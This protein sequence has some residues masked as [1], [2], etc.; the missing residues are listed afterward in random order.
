MTPRSRRLWRPVFAIAVGSVIVALVVCVLRPRGELSPQTE[1]AAWKELATRGNDLRLWLRFID[2]HADEE[3]SPISDEAIRRQLARI[4]SGSVATLAAFWYEHVSKEAKPDAQTLA[5]A[6]ATKPP[7]YAN[8]LLARAALDD[9]D[10]QWQEAARRFE[11]EGLAF[12]DDWRDLE[13]A[14]ATYVDHDA[15]DEVRKRSHDPRY[16]KVLHASFRLELAIH[17]RDWAGILVWLWPAG[18]VATKPWPIALAVLSAVLWLIITTRLGRVIDHVRGRALLYTLAFILGIL[19]IYPTLLISVVEEDIFH[20]RI[21]NQTVPDGLYFIFGVGLR[22]EAAKLLLFLP[23][24]PALLRRGS[25]IEVMTCGA[26]VG[27]GF[28][29]E[30]NIGYFSQYAAGVALSRFLT[31]N[32]LHMSLTALAAMSVF[33]EKRGRSMPHDRF[34]V[35]FPLIV[36]IHGAYDFFL[37]DPEFSGFS[38]LSMFLLILVA[39]QFLRQLLIAT[40]R[41]EE[42]GVLRLF[43]WSLTL[44]TGVSYIY[45]TTLVGPLAAFRLI[46]VGSVGVAFVIYVFVRELT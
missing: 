33:D 11:R 32:F 15:W 36:L 13:R 8:Y 44:L 18:Y 26:L 7:R 20:F 4:P 16:G 9:E 14:L 39:Q 28:A 19:S 24:L 46:A 2:L 27:L 10:E 21:V 30:E 25:R 17:D 22:E 23:L 29:A 41:F 12:P 42:E 31:A 40:S 38:I 43:V 45:A 1:R 6:D 35:M 34:N 5:L 37:S 3:D